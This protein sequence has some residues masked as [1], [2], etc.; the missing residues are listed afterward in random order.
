ME[1]ELMLLFFLAAETFRDFQVRRTVEAYNAGGDQKREALA[2]VRFGKQWE[3]I[4]KK[5]VDFKTFFETVG[6]GDPQ[7]STFAIDVDTKSGANLLAEM[8]QKAAAA[9]LYKLGIAQST[10]VDYDKLTKI[11]KEQDLE[12]QRLLNDQTKKTGG[13]NFLTHTQLLGEAYAALNAFMALDNLDDFGRSDLETKINNTPNRIDLR[14]V[15]WGKGRSPLLNGK[16][17][18][19]SQK[20]NRQTLEDFLDTNTPTN[21]HALF[22]ERFINIDFDKSLKYFKKYVQ[23]NFKGIENAQYYFLLTANNLAKTDLKVI[24]KILDAQE[25]RK[26]H[27]KFIT[28]VLRDNTD[29][30]DQIKPYLKKYNKE[31][32]LEIQENH[33]AL[34]SYFRHDL[35]LKASNIDKILDAFLDV[36]EP[37]NIHGKLLSELMRKEIRNG[38]LDK[39]L[40]YFQTYENKKFGKIDEN[41][42]ETLKDW[43]AKKDLETFL[44]TNSPENIHGELLFELI[45]NEVLA[46]KLDKS[47]P[48]LQ[49]YDKVSFGKISNNEL[50]SILQA[51]SG[52]PDIDKFFAGSPSAIRVSF[53]QIMMNQESKKSNTLNKSLKYLKQEFSKPE[54]QRYDES[55]KNNFIET[56]NRFIDIKNADQ[57][58]TLLEVNTPQEIHWKFLLNIMH[59]ELKNSNATSADQALK[60]FKQ[61]NYKNFV[62]LN[63]D[64]KLH[65]LWLPDD[66]EKEKVSQYINWDE[67]A[68]P[69]DYVLRTILPMIP[70]GTSRDDLIF[71]KM[72]P[73]LKPSLPLLGAYLDLIYD[74]TP[75]RLDQIIQYDENFDLSYML[76]LALKHKISPSKNAWESFS[77]EKMRDYRAMNFQ[78][79]ALNQIK[80]WDPRL[81]FMILMQH[82]S[83]SQP[84]DLHERLNNLIP[85]ITEPLQNE[86]LNEKIVTPLNEDA[87]YTHSLNF[88]NKLD[89][90]I[91]IRW[92]K[93]IFKELKNQNAFHEFLSIFPENLQLDI[94][95][96]EIFKHTSRSFDWSA[97]DR[98]EKMKLLR[99]ANI[100][101]DD[102]KDPSP[103][104]TMITAFHSLIGFI[105]PYNLNAI[106]HNISKHIEK[107]DIKERSSLKTKL[108]NNTNTE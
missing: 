49:Q 44:N 1:D 58:A 6:F 31:G 74:L 67:I 83:F 73:K 94:A 51:W 29:L 75:K 90:S 10:E 91:R 20:I 57:I 71:D 86:Y 34:Q 88:L 84:T 61:Y 33:S 17:L 60:Y 47:L 54:F 18:I 69:P 72:L 52:N 22:L 64:I 97:V 21:I 19:L 26:I 23:A 56:I 43:K 68:A 85:H 12:V 45:L 96:G 25:L 42:Q 13:E 50:K 48:P 9:E 28:N 55:I 36:P 100:T 39:S 5:G 99:S 7:N 78:D 103:V 14:H 37:T 15:N 101:L 92:A 35:D 95:E 108:E 40:T 3:D 76:H 2:K 4:E 8:R 77:E 79:D 27:V 53:L 82:I 16:I 59:R 80:T 104:D 65:F 32:V 38:K 89:S 11:V 41:L 62:T 24:Q 63:N 81:Q 46:G 106:K 87:F 98:K 105:E 66:K 107:A 93:H 30:F 102:P 70:K